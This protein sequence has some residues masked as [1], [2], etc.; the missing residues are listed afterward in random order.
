MWDCSSSAKFRTTMFYDKYKVP[1]V[2]G[3]RVLGVGGASVHV[4]R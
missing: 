2:K 4:E 1:S 3:E